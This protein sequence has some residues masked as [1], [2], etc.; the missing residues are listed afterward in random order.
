[1]EGEQ[2]FEVEGGSAMEALVG[3]QG[4]FVLD[5]VLNRQSVEGFKD[6][7]DVIVRLHPHQDLGS[8]VLNVLQLLDVLA[9]DPDE[10][11]VAV[12]QPGGD[13]GVDKLLGVRESVWDGALRCS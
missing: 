1:M 3:Q 2:F 7:C 8:T 9:G 11:C 12:V 6:R 10:E 13:E 4:D 5:P